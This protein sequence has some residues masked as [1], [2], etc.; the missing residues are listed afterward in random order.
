MFFLNFFRAKLQYT[1][2]LTH[3][4]LTSIV[5]TFSKEIYEVNLS[6]P[7]F[8]ENIVPYFNPYA[9]AWWLVWTTQNDA[10]KAEK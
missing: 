1:A 4:Q 7:S 5:K 6:N 2:F 9:C 10:K 3:I 8:Y